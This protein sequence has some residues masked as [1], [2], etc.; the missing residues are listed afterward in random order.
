LYETFEK[1]YFAFALKLIRS[2]TAFKLIRSYT[3]LS[4][5]EDLEDWTQ[6][7]ACEET[8]VDLFSG[9]EYLK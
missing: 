8:K 1:H 4:C 2:C 5:W 9:Q 7:Q 6:Q 3:E